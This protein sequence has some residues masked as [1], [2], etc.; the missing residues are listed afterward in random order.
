MST[1]K[2]KGWLVTM[3][4]VVM[5]MMLAIT[6]SCGGKKTAS[7]PRDNT[8]LQEDKSAMM[9]RVDAAMEE[10]PAAAEEEESSGSDFFDF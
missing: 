2:S 5:A 3:M 7:V 1:K 4:A 6:V 9:D 10:A 8:A